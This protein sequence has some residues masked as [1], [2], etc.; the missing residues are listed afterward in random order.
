MF[1]AVCGVTAIDALE[2]QLHGANFSFIAVII[3][4]SSL[5]LGR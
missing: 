5:F 4:K 3:T 2:A 1:I